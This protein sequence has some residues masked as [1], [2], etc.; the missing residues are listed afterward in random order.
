MKAA[1]PVC[2]CFLFI[3]HVYVLFC[4]Y[5]F[6]LSVVIFLAM[7]L[8]VILWVWVVAFCFW[9]L[10]CFGSG[11][12]ALIASGWLGRSAWFGDLGGLLDC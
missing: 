2:S 8:I 11:L 1:F 9:V 10:L 3:R 7:C 5:Y 4:I 12:D 6:S